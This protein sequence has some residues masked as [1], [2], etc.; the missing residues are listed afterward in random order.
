VMNETFPSIRPAIAAP[1]RDRPTAR[2][3]PVATGTLR[4]TYTS[5][6]LST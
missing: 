1:P 5:S 3:F 2:R 6:D 4:T